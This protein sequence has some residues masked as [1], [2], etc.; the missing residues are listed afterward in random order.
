M[1]FVNRVVTVHWV[2]P[3]KVAEAEVDPDIIVLSESD[4]VLTASFD[5]G[6]RIPVSLENVV[7]LEVNMDWVRPITSPLRVPKSRRYCALP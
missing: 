4:D 5:Q 7:L 6:R 1:V 3:H 2:A